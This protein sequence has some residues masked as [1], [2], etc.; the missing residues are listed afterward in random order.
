MGSEEE[1]GVRS[2]LH[3]GQDG[4]RTFAFAFDKGDEAVEG[5]TNF[6]EDGGVGAANLTAVGA[7]GDATL[8]D[9]DRDRKVYGKIPVEEQVEVLSLL[10]DI[11]LED[12]GPQLHAHAVVGR[13]DAT[14][15]DGDLLEGHV[16]PT[17]GVVLGE[18]PDH[19]KKRTDEE[20]GFALID[21]ED[22]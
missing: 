4:Q 22:G 11:A 19:L 14:T 7:L 12:G 3:H 6:A 15:G 9:F 10:G 21:V 18:S 5:L 1:V 20:T 17:L 8:G 13:Y 2:K 16:W